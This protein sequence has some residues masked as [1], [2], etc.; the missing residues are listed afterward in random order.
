MLPFPG[1]HPAALVPFPAPFR[2]RHRCGGAVEA[3]GTGPNHR[4]TSHDVRLSPLSSVRGNWLNSTGL[5]TSQRDVPGRHVDELPGVAT[6]AGPELLPGT[7]RLPSRLPAAGR[8]LLELLHCAHER[9]RHEAHR[10]S[11]W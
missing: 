8:P 7:A 5:A 4:R 1:A 10:L 9:Q 3:C 11:G 2:A 6:G